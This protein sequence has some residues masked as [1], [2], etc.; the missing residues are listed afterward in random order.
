M[1]ALKINPLDENSGFAKSKA[2]N[3][4]TALEAYRVDGTG[5]KHM[6]N[7]AKVNNMSAIQAMQALVAYDRYRL[8]KPA[9]YDLKD[10]EKTPDHN[11][12]ITVP[13]APGTSEDLDAG[14][15]PGKDNGNI[16]N[17]PD[18]SN[19]PNASTADKTQIKNTVKTGDV[20]SVW[21][22]CMLMIAAGGA[23][24]GTV[25]YRRKMI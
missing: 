25:V 6:M 22:F 4:L 17:T 18:N 23:A 12:E 16:G 24:A 10:A 19:T 15:V 9:L 3:L 7:D 13:S 5:F 2:R 14:K 11:E 21:L 8:G 20:T 1:T